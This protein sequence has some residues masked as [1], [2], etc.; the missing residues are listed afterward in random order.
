MKLR[1]KNKKYMKEGLHRKYTVL[2]TNPPKS[3]TICKGRVSQKQLD[4]DLLNSS[5]HVEAND[6]NLVFI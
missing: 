2:K 1:D 3:V 4:L 5:S 6:K